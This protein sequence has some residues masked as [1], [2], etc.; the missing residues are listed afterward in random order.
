M[1]ISKKFVRDSNEIGCYKDN[2]NSEA[3]QVR[4]EK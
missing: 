1:V 3:L 4:N 2:L